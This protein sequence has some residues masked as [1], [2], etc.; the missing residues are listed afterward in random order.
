[1]A[2]VMRFTLDLDDSI[3][4]ACDAQIRDLGRMIPS[5]NAYIG[6]VLA[7]VHDVPV[8]GKLAASME[9]I[10]ARRNELPASGEVARGEQEH[11]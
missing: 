10:N 9:K 5:R 8:A 6:Y 4:A 1:M 7:M 11:S 2:F 3:V